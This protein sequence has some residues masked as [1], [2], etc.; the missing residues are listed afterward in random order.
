MMAFAMALEVAH[1][2]HAS[3]MRIRADVDDCTCLLECF[4]GDE[5]R[6]LDNEAS[7]SMDDV[8]YYR[9]LAS[10]SH[11]EAAGLVFS[12]SK[13]GRHR[14]LEVDL[15]GVTRPAG[16]AGEFYEFVM[17]LISEQWGSS[18]RGVE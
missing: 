16:S 4:D 2:R 5:W 6:P 8:E 12:E 10:S 13:S 9:A 3:K 15:S 17:K 18:H 7:Q 11:A 1:S 14:H